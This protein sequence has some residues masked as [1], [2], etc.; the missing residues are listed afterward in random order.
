MLLDPI[1]EDIQS[2]YSQFLK[3]KA[4]KPRMGQKQMIAEI[5]KSLSLIES[6]AE[7]IRTNEAGVSVIEAGTGTGKTVA[8]LI[9]TLPFAKAFNKT[10]VV[11]TATVALQEQII[12]KDLPEIKK[13][14]G[15]DFRFALAKGRGRYLCLTKLESQLNMDIDQQPLWGA[16]TFSPVAEQT[17]AKLDIMAQSLLTG[18]WNGEKDSLDL[19]IDDESWRKLT[20][21]RAECSGRR[22]QHVSQCRFFK[23]REELTKVDCI[24]ANH[25]LVMADLALGGGVILPPSAETIFVFDEAHHLSS[26][27]IQHFSSRMRINSTLY[28]CDQTLKDI[29]LIEQQFSVFDDLIKQVRDIPANI[30]NLKLGM[31]KLTPLVEP[32]LAETL[33][34]SHYRDENLPHFRFAQGIIPENIVDNLTTVLPIIQQLLEQIDDIKKI[35]N[36]Q[37][38]TNFSGLSLNE[39]EQCVTIF[40]QIETVL[41]KIYSLFSQYI[42]PQGEI[43][44][45]RWIQPIATANSIDYE[46]RASPLLAAQTLEQYLWSQHFAV[47]L[48]SATLTA[49]GSF[50]RFNQQ[51]GLPAHARQLQVAS[52]FDYYH[53]AQFIVPALQVEPHNQQAHSEEIAQI[54]PS[55]VKDDQAILV[56]FASKKQLNQVIDLLDS[57][58]LEQV[59]IQN[60]LSKQQLIDTHKEQ[61]KNKKRS[62]IFGLAS[63]AEGI[64]L[65]GELLTHVII[66]KLPFGVPN[67]PIESA[68]SEWLES[69]GKNPF[70]E[71]TLPDASRKLIQACGR[72]I[73]TESDQGKITLLDKRIL[74]KGYG[75][76]LLA[77]LPPFKQ[78]LG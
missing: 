21:D 51:I 63:F 45:S 14:T 33:S 18:T 2:A 34:L 53:K 77:A 39:L 35:I 72:L 55:L 64:D 26:I 36:D 52:P 57:D 76:K 46:L 30:K 13:H 58:F 17:R 19:D 40:G 49:L 9:A 66:V 7:G 59:L 32:I 5:A 60:Q 42:K 15:L 73:R 23:A 67:D 16:D 20:A 4:I 31:Q 37:L 69:Q 6:D 8:Y 10:L 71:I 43:P 29:Q 38:D 61:V 3:S 50:E 54:L 11:S 47:I 74:T 65:P 75:K 1:K 24:V 41:D 62:I 28:W 27:A 44:D 70:Q 78:Q 22:C 12:K 25:D 56:L 48:T 68:F